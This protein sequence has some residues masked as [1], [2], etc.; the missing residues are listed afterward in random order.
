MILNLTTTPYPEWN[1][2]ITAGLTQECKALTGIHEDVIP[3]YIYIEN[4]GTFKGGIILEQHG[5]I[6]WIDSIWL[7]PK[8]RK[9]GL[10]K[11]LLEK[12]TTLA[13]E[14]K[15]TQLQLNTYFEHA[16]KFFVSCGFE[17]VAVIPKWKYGLDCYLMR[18]MIE[19]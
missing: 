19:K 6:L 13:R 17:D 8:Y 7:E 1:N 16:H 14:Q 15:A 12:A 4:Q 5:N 3:Q 2:K 9:K 10:G 18:R 11:Q